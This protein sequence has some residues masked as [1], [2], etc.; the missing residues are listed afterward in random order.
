MGWIEP[1][2]GVVKY[3]FQCLFLY[4]DFMA[5]AW[6]FWSRR[7]I[8]SF[9]A[10]AVATSHPS[11]E[12]PH[13]SITDW[14][15]TAT[16]IFPYSYSSDKEIRVG[17]ICHELPEGWRWQLQLHP[18]HNQATTAPPDGCFPACYSSTAWAQTQFSPPHSEQICTRLPAQLPAGSMLNACAF[19][20][21]EM[22][23]NW[24][25]V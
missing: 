11:C 12:K 18:F 13:Q 8:I 2:I 19:V 1:Y 14:K 15:P 16:V 6:T 9:N 24:E 7:G 4:F 3:A 22:H 10:V 21:R 17:Q 20:A 5:V 23:D 25:V